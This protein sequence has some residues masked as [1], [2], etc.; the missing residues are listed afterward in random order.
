MTYGL[1]V[2]GY[3]LKK[4]EILQKKAVRMVDKSFFLEHTDP[5][6]KKYNILKVSDIFKFKIFNLFYKIV[7]KTAPVKIQDII[8]LSDIS[9]WSRQH[10]QP[11]VSPYCPSTNSAKECLRFSLPSLINLCPE[12]YIAWLNTKTENRF[13]QLVRCD[14]I[15]EYSEAPCTDANC[16]ACRLKNL[17]QSS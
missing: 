1:L 15:E 13:N 16:Y 11:L 3:N 10:L 6:F 17:L 5:I 9:L 2:W 14:L 4:I 12:N 8:S 7:N